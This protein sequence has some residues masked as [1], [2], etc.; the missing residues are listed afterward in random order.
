LIE[1]HCEKGKGRD[2]QSEK[3]GERPSAFVQNMD[4]RFEILDI[5]PSMI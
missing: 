2:T 3:K 4:F 5:G 1:G